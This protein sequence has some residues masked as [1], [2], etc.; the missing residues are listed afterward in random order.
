M[1][2]SLALNDKDLTYHPQRFPSVL[3]E[4]IGVSV[5]VEASS[6]SNLVF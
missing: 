4:L 2:T 1:T 3:S 6:F 5:S